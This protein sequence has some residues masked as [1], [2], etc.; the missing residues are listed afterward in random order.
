MHPRPPGLFWATPSSAWLHWHPSPRQR[1]PPGLR[2]GLRLRARQPRGSLSGRAQSGPPSSF[3]EARSPCNWMHTRT[4]FVSVDWSQAGLLSVALRPRRV[5]SGPNSSFRSQLYHPELCDPG[6][7][8][9]LGAS[10]ASSVKWAWRAAAR[11]KG[12]VPGAERAPQLPL[13]LIRTECVPPS[14]YDEALS[15]NGTVFG[16]GVFM[17]GMSSQGWGLDPIG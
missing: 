9:P 5:A 1:Q 4:A 6:G 15:P 10:L 11:R 16:D 17:E 7:S 8:V 14:P 3:G 2:L 13:H 12:K